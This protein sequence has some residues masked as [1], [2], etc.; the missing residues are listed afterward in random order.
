MI[1]AIDL[2]RS[3]IAA[4]SVILLPGH[5]I[6]CT[7]IYPQVSC[8]RTQLQLSHR[9]NPV[10]IQLFIGQ[11]NHGYITVVKRLCLPVIEQ[12]CAGDVIGLKWVNVDHERVF[13][14]VFHHNI[15]MQAN[16]DPLTHP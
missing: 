2:Q 8:T 10:D 9:L 16:R 13:L 12:R 11:G 6:Y 4:L 14:T 5:T 3:K 7:E 1:K 15:D